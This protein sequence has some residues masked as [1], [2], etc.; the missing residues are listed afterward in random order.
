MTS[1]A[2]SAQNVTNSV[3]A[4]MLQ[5]KLLTPAKA[6]LRCFAVF[7]FALADALASARRSSPLLHETRTMEASEDNTESVYHL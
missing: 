6:R 4:M 1:L 2:I 7:V 5:K 3:S